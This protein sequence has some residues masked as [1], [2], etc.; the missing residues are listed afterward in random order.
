VTR[1]TESDKA[2]ELK[3][4][5]AEVVAGSVTDVEFVRSAIPGAYGVYLVTLVSPEEEAVGKAAVDE[6]KK[7]GIKHVVSTRSSTK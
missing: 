1:N 6:C 2:K 3:A 5:G 4:A 7:A